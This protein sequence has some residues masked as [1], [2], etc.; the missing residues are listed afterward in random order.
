[1]NARTALIALTVA[2]VASTSILAATRKVGDKAPPL[3]IKEWVRGDKVDVTSD[4]GDM[5]YVVE[6]WATWCGPC[7]QSI[8]HLTHLQKEY[9]DK[10]VV[11]GVTTKDQRQ[12]L[13]DVQRF[14]KRMGERMAYTVAFDDGEQ[15]DKAYMQ[16]FEKRGIPQAFVIDRHGKIVWEGHP[17]FGMDAVIKTIMTEDYTIEKLKRVGEKAAE[18]M[19]KE[20]Q[21]RSEM[22]Q[23]Y[24]AH[25]SME[26][27]SKKL[28]EM[29]QALL[30]E[31]RDD[32][33]FLNQLSWTIMDQAGLEF[34]DLDLALE[35]AK[36]ANELTKGDDPSILDTY[37]RALF[38]NDQV[39]AAIEHQ[40]KALKLL[41]E[42]ARGREHYAEALKRYLKAAEENG[43]V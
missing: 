37:A 36:I 1:M 8:P 32:A 22:M 27:E 11:I 24:F 5:V 29:G 41:G 16:A 39:E 14:V 30:K 17:M 4:K 26:G 42:D 3:Q 33:M 38:E 25:V 35:A 9:K 12:D 10:L 31:V 19:M 20:M 40:K 18:E 2:L 34:R 43:R 21:R 6:F 23:E 15:T 13:K 7:I 28:R